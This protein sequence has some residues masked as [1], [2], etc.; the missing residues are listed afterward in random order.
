MR[1]NIL[2]GILALSALLVGTLLVA[3]FVTTTT[4]YSDK[5]LLLLIADE[6]EDMDSDDLHE[7]VSYETAVAL[8]RISEEEAIA[9]ANNAVDL[10]QTGKMTDIE[11]ERENGV[12][13][14]AVE[15]TK[16]GIETD[17]K[18]HAET[19]EVILIESDLDEEDQD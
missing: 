1:G 16:N 5:S 15:Y 14:Y 9:I 6:D 12:V 4:E 3:A 11:L 7:K 19:G 17:V 18:I 2:L 13:V 8:D 10:S